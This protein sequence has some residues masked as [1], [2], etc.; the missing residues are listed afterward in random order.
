MRAE[1]ATH[2]HR[3]D[4][5]RAGRKASKEGGMLGWEVHAREAVN[6]HRTSSTNPSYPNPHVCNDPHVSLQSAVVTTRN[7]TA[8]G[9]GEHAPCADGAHALHIHLLLVQ[10]RLVRCLGLLLSHALR[11]QFLLVLQQLSIRPAGAGSGPRTPSRDKA[12]ANQSPY[13]SEP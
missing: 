7:L 12:R 9:T 13:H 8:Q 5:G 4:A 2:V 10:L 6:H 11:L 1:G 3:F